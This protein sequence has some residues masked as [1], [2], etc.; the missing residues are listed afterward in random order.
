MAPSVIGSAAGVTPAWLTEVLRA[1]G[2]IGEDSSVVA[3]RADAIGT[4]QVG[5]N[6]RFTLEYEGVPGPPSLVCK[7]GSSDPASA[8]AGVSMK[9][10]ETE[11]AFYRDLA[12]SL[13]VSRPYC[14]FAAVIPGTAEAVVVMEDLAPAVQGDQIEGCS[15]AEAELAMDEAARLHGPRWGDDALL[16]IPWLRHDGRGGGLETALPHVWEA[17]VA[18]YGSSV[19]PVT[20]VA[21]KELTELGPLLAARQLRVLSP[22][23]TDFR[24]DNMLFG[25]GEVR[26]L[27]VVDWQTVALGSGPRDVAYFLGN[28]F[29][30]EVRRSAERDLVARYHRRLV[31]DYGVDDFSFEECWNDVVRSSYSSLAMAVFA[32]MTVGRTERGDAMF[33]AMANR[34]AQMAA[35]L[36]APLAIRSG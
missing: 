35:D 26:P 9:L 7:F 14:Y 3:H 33:M 13:D 28:A 30:P 5:N 25:R 36:D 22:A 10:Y 17:F 6:V 11:V 34:S 23:H 31:E 29:K 15:V 27:T 1:D 4:G 20:L 8:A 2:A 18:R 21:G 32:S 19:E 24:L 16:S 12:G